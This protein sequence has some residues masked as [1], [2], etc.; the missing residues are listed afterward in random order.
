M[1][2]LIEFN[3]SPA[4]QEMFPEFSSLMVYGSVDEPMFPIQQVLDMLQISKIH[5]DR[6]FDEHDDY[7][8][9]SVRAK[10]GKL[11][12]QNLF[13][14]QGL[15]NALSRNRGDIGKRFR[16]FVT[17]VFKELRLRG[18]VTLT[19]AISKLQKE[20]ANKDQYIRVLDDECERM[21]EK[22][23]IR[24]SESE[25]L[26][27]QL[28][29]AEQRTVRLWQ[30]KR[31]LED[32]DVRVERNLEWADVDSKL[33][34]LTKTKL[35]TPFY[36]SR[37]DEDDVDEVSIWKMSKTPSDNSFTIHVWPGTTQKIITDWLIEREYGVKGKSGWVKNAFEGSPHD[38]KDAITSL[39][40][41]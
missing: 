22:E 25:E 23:T 20:L 38:I 10:D 19:D 29:S 37:V 6:E 40:L 30:V 36:F 2:D 35:L 34:A 12:E 28:M 32:E 41:R 8:K 3:R 5:L 13:T 33:W 26:R 18:Q 15:Y 14:E 24:D 17:I 1:T 11:R 7:V 39:L 31:E 21:R 4:M 16:K 9:L 27:E